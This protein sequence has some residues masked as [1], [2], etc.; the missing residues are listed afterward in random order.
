[1]LRIR[2]RRCEQ[3]FI[4]TDDMPPRGKCPNPDCEGSYDVHEALK[5]NLAAR[6]PTAAN[7]PSCPVCSHAIPSR[8]GFCPHCGEFVAGSRHI[9][10]R[11]LLFLAILILLVLAALVRYSLNP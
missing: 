10:K 5:E 3:K 4:W 7:T 8:W 2:C 9:R 11:D 6:T 1:M